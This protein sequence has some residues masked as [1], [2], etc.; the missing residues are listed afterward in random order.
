[1]RGGDDLGRLHERLVV[2]GNRE[3]A[4]P[5]A[6]SL[7]RLGTRDLLIE[8]IDVSVLDHGVERLKD[9]ILKECGV[10]TLGEVV[11]LS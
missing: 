1:M 6:F 7:G 11:Q 2:R 3:N 4:C 10:H 9:T 5:I 8:S